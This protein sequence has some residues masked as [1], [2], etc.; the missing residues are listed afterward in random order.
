MTKPK[1]TGR[2]SFAKPRLQNIP[3]PLTPEQRKLSRKIR[4][5]F[6]PPGYTFC[7]PDYSGFELRLAAQI[8]DE[9]KKA[10]S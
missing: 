5:A 3:I 9:L 10:N 2:M 8:A 4:K 1:N 7:F 6:L